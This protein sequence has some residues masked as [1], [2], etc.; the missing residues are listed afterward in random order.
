MTPLVYI[1]KYVREIDYTI[2]TW[3]DKNGGKTDISFEFLDIIDFPLKKI[4]ASIKRLTKDGLLKTN[5]DKSGII[6]IELTP[7][8]QSFLSEHIVRKIVGKR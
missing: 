8:A 2:L 1:P 3:L 5:A 6:D 4:E 7:K